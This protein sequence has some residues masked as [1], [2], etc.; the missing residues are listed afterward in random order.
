MPSLPGQHWAVSVDLSGFRVA[1]DQLRPDGQARKIFYKNEDPRINL[2]VVIKPVEPGTTAAQIRDD[3]MADNKDKPLQMVNLRKSDLMGPSFEYFLEDPVRGGP[4]HQKHVHG[5]LVYGGYRVE[6]HVSI[7]RY[8]PADQAW[9]DGLLIGV[10]L[11]VGGE[12]R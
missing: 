2:T 12:A 10:G 11:M 4:L 6:I 9:L 1:D 7:T 3:R 5:F 8:K